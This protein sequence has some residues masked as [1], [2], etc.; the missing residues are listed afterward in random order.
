M[1]AVRF[2]LDRLAFAALAFA[3]LF[4]ARVLMVTPAA[5]TSV[6]VPIVQAPSASR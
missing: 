5:P 3:L 2:I 4:A 6:V 1:A